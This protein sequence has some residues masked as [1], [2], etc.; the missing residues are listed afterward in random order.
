MD[1]L[2]LCANRYSLRSFSDKPVPDDVLDQILEAGRLA[3]TAM[4]RQPQRIYVLRSE[5]ALAK[6]R[7]IQKC[8]DATTV[9]LICGDTSVACNRPR[10]DHCLAEMDC[11]IVTTHMML[12]AESLGVGSCWIC[13]FDVPA[14]AKAFDLPDH[15][16]PYMLLP[17]GYPTED[18]A[19]NP[20]HFE[21]YPIEETVTKL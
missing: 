8:Y 7:G 1:F 14:V 15:I 11:S 18:A 17:L 9:L 5:D 6:I 13:A 12:A 16:I 20:R 2:K 19:P 4:N 21:R 10:V 3:P